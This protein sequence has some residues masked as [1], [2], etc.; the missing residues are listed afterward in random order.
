MTLVFLRAKASESVFEG[1]PF[2]CLQSYVLFMEESYTYESIV[3]IGFTFLSLGY[4]AFLLNTN[5]EFYGNLEEQIETYP[6]ILMKLILVLLF[7]V[8]SFLR[9]TSEALFL[10]VFS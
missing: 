8:D 9:A 6:S 5:G 3:S 4:T 2:L 10:K 1:A 7:V